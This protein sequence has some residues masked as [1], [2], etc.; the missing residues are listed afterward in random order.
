MMTNSFPAPM[1][2]KHSISSAA[3]RIYL[4]WGDMRILRL[5][6]QKNF[7]SGI[8]S[9]HREKMIAADSSGQC[10]EEFFVFSVEEIVLFPYKVI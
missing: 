2:P 3:M 10:L 6:Q 8:Y 4:F 1:M 5:S 9:D 7:V